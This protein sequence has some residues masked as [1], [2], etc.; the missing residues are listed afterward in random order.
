MTQRAAVAYIQPTPFPSASIAMSTSATIEEPQS[1]VA[2]GPASS[3]AAFFKAAFLQDSSSP[4]QRMSRHVKSKSRGRGEMSIPGYSGESSLYRTREH[5]RSA[6]KAPSPSKHGRGVV[7]QLPVGGGG[8]GQCCCGGS[9]GGWGGI[10][11]GAFDLSALSST[12]GGIARRTTGQT[13]VDCAAGCACGCSGKI[14]I[15]VCRA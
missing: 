10:F 3:K 4:P 13:C 6:E 8:S 12:F 14:P 2:S 15:C 9:S 7:A 1:G 11:G 5:Y